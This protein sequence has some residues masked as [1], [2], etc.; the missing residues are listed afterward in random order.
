MNGVVVGVDESPA[1]QEA[2][3][4]AWSYARLRQMPMRVV[5]AWDYIAQHHADKTP[6]G[7]PYSPEI[8]HHELRELVDR[9][10][11][12]N[13][14]VACEA[15]L[16]HPPAA[17]LSASKS[18]DLVV[19]GSRGQGGF[20]DL[21]LG[22]VAR[23]VLHHADCPVAVVRGPADQI[24]GPI[25]VGTDGSDHSLRA[26]DWAA[27]F[28]AEANRR[29]VVVLAWRAPLVGPVFYPLMTDWE[30]AAR[31]AAAELDRAVDRIRVRGARVDA[32]P[33]Q[34]S[35]AAE[36]LAT[37]DSE[38]AYLLVV[39]AR[40]SS[41]FPGSLLGSVSDQVVHHANVPVVVVR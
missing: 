29:L 20:R 21:L 15:V 24:D 35:A 3:R 12:P 13:N 40:G 9:A 17:I 36:L 23:E 30:G 1:A 25:V 28:A 32:R 4:W 8:A 34:G 33:I 11:G 19:V 10:L 18:A 14:G 27:S 38:R 37:A 16:E 7:A 31:R 5:M 22:S 2:L 41:G 26:L 39:G 6:F